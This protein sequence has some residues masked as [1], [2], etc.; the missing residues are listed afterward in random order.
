M[1]Q[2]AIQLSGVALVL[3]PIVVALT[4][5]TKTFIQ[6]S[7]F[8]PVVALVLGV[9]GALVLIPGS[10]AVSSVTGIVIGLTAAGVYSG[11]KAVT[12]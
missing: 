9:V 3:V 6:D 4:S 8:Y 7:R 2:T 5:I 11:A 1:E 10:I 12:S